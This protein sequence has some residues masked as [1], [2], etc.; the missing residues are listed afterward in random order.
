MD[1]QQEVARQVGALPFVLL[2][3]KHDLSGQW[4]VD[5]TWLARQRERGWHILFTSA[6]S[7]EAV[8]AAF[9]HLARNLVERTV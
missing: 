9:E 8:P 2:I 7:G 5:E 3:N 4:R 1:I 6:L